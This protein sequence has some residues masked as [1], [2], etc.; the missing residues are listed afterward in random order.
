MASVNPSNLQTIRQQLK[1]LRM[2][3]Q[4]FIARTSVRRD[5]WAQSD[6]IKHLEMAEE[7]LKRAKINYN[8]SEI[9]D[10]DVLIDDLLDV[11]NY[12]VFVIRRLMNLVP[13]G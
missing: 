2:A 8:E 9:L 4:I 3:H 1:V 6:P 11:I 7:K 5:L 13:N 10:G 12:V